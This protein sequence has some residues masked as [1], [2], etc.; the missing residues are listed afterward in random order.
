MFARKDKIDVWYESPAKHLIQNPLTKEIL[1]VQ[2]EKQ[3]ELINVRANCGVIMCCGGF[4]DSVEKMANYL[5]NP[6]KENL[7]PCVYKQREYTRGTI[8]YFL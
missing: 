1:G 6:V 3:G 4:Q 8:S 2:I 5:H 7:K